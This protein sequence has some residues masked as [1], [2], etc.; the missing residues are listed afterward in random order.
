MDDPTLPLLG[1]LPVSGK[2]LDFRFAGRLLSSDGGIL[3]LREVE[4]RLGV[5]DRMAACIYVPRA[6]EHITQSLADII[7]SG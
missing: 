5:A 2:R 1:L 7:G 4:Q 3:L 6:P